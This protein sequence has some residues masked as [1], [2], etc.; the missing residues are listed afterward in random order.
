MIQVD[1]R[2]LIEKLNSTCRRTLEAAAG[3]TLS[4]SHYNIEVEHWLLKLLEIPETDLAAILR[5]YEIDAGR[6]AAD[7]TRTLDRLKTGNSR[8]PALSPQVVSLMR[9][10]WLAAS[11]GHGASLVR[12]GHLLCAF[13]SDDVFVQAAREASAQFNRIQVENLRRDL[14]KITAATGEASPVEGAAPGAAAVA[15]KSLTS[16]E[17]PALGILPWTSIPLI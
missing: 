13:L 2:S 7:L 12:S 9:E 11:L 8:A 4:R 10:A 17:H 15:G 3:L 14:N 1:L 16:G 5:H 6:L